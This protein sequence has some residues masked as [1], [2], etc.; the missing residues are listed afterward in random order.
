MTQVG[1]FLRDVRKRKGLSIDEIAEG[2]GI[3]AQYIDALE[4]G[5]Y[6]KIPGD[7]FIK[8]F[9]RNYGN[10][11]N[12]DGNA[13]VEQYKN[14]TLLKDETIKAALLSV[15]EENREIADVASKKTFF[16]GI[17]S[18]FQKLK[19]FIYDNIYETIEVDDEKEDNI[20]IITS[21]KGGSERQRLTNPVEAAAANKSPFFNYRIFIRVFTV[22]LL[23][24]VCFMVYF[25]L[26]GT[27]SSPKPANG[28]TAFTDTIKSEHSSDKEAA[29][30]SSD[31]ITTK[32]TNTVKELVETVDSKVAT[33]KKDLTAIVADPANSDDVIV[34]ITYKEP[35]W[36]EVESDGKTVETATIAKGTT[37]T[38]KATKE[39]KVKLGSIRNVEIKVNG[40]VVPYGEKEWGTVEKIFKK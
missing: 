33:T 39:I 31:K 40:N 5:D 23:L 30:K 7:V 1:D 18:A 38:Y 6:E 11:L 20:N 25:F 8:G 19:N 16:S 15:D 34:Q 22:S 13:L 29:L 35:V 28:T 12:L 26:T 21:P 17:S 37:K 4:N 2:T 9:I 3:R 10:F 24:F 36:T 14:H 27:K 32:I